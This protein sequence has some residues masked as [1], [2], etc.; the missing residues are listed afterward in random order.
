MFMICDVS[1]CCESDRTSH[2]AVTTLLLH[3]LLYIMTRVR[4]GP[5]ATRCVLTQLRRVVSAAHVPACLC[6]WGPCAATAIT[7]AE[8]HMCAL[9]GRCCRR[10]SRVH[11]SRSAR[12][13]HPQI[14][15]WLPQRLSECACVCV[16]HSQHVCK[17][18]AGGVW[19]CGSGSE[20]DVDLFCYSCRH[21][22]NYKQTRQNHSLRTHFCTQA[23]VFASSLGQ[24]YMNK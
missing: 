10:H 7:S 18:N 6:A 2:L 4:N 22:E 11:K 9:S 12:E 13:Y 21:F 16:V 14:I 20:A 19:A 23:L 15:E 8:P 1:I 24:T 3:G 5:L 17:P